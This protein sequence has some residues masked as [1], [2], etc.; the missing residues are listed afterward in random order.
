MPGSI[1]PVWVPE[2][3]ETKL[4]SM[5]AFPVDL[6]IPQESRESPRRKR[7]PLLL[8]F[9]AAMLLP[10]T[11]H[12]T[13][14]RNPAVFLLLID[15]IRLA[16]CASIFVSARHAGVKEGI[17]AT[18]FLGVVFL[19]A[20]MLDF[21][22][23]LSFGGAWETGDLGTGFSSSSVAR[24]I[25]AFGIFMYPLILRRRITER[26]W[27]PWALLLML[28]LTGFSV[29]GQTA[30]RETVVGAG[31]VGRWSRIGAPTALCFAA[32]YTFVQRHTMETRLSRAI[33]G[34]ALGTAA[35]Q[36]LL[37]L[38]P[39]S[40]P[41]NYLFAHATKTF[42]IVPLFLAVVHLNVAKP[43]N[44][45]LQRLRMSESGLRAAYGMQE[46]RIAE[47][48]A[49]LENVLERLK[50]N[51]RR[52][53][54]I[55]D[56][57]KDFVWL[58]NFDGLTVEYASPSF[59]RIW[60]NS[61]ENLYSDPEILVNGIHPEDR[62]R[63][64]LA[65][66][67]ERERG[68]SMEYRVLH[69][70]GSIRWIRDRAFPVNEDGYAGL[71]GVATDI[72]DEILLR[73]EIENHRQSL[74]K[75]VSSRTEELRAAN[76][77]LEADIEQRRKA[78]RALKQREKLF[79]SVV[80]QSHD[81]V[82]IVN[83]RG[84]VIEW[85]ERMATISGI[86]YQQACGKPILDIWDEL[87]LGA[88]SET[89][90]PE[91][92]A[93]QVRNLV[94][95]GIEPDW[96]GVGEV[97]ILTSNQERRLVGVSIF[98]VTGI[99][100]LIT[101]AIVRDV[102]KD[103]EN[104]ARTESA[105][106][107]PSENPH[108][109]L[110][111]S[112]EG[113]V[114][115]AN[116][117]SEI[118]LNRWGTGAG[119]KVPD[120]ICALVLEVWN[121]KSGRNCEVRICEKTFSLD[122]IPVA[123]S[124]YVNMYGR[125]IS[126][127]IA[128][129]NRVVESEDKHRQLLENLNEGLWSFDKDGKT[130]F[131]NRKM[132]AML[133]CS[134]EELRQK[135]VR[136]FIFPGDGTGM[137][138]D[139]IRRSEEKTG[140]LELELVRCDGSRLWALLEVSSLENEE[141]ESGGTLACVL[142][143]SSRKTAERMNAAL[144]EINAELLTGH[145]TRTILRK[146]IEKASVALL[147]ESAAILMREEGCWVVREQ[148]GML[149]LRTGTVLGDH[150]VVLAHRAVTA[151]TVI[152]IENADDDLQA[153]A[154][155]M[156]PENTGSVIIVPILMWKTTVGVMYFRNASISSEARNF[157]EGVGAAL[158]L[159]LESSRLFDEL[160]NELTARRRV[161]EELRDTQS[162][163]SELV[164]RQKHELVH[165]RETL[166]E[167]IDQRVEAQRALSQRQLA[168]E[169]VY[170]MATTFGTSLGTLFDQVTLSIA[171]ILDIEFVSIHNVQDGR[172]CALSQ[173]FHGRLTK[174]TD[175]AVPCSMCR[176]S[177]D[178]KLLVQHSQNLRNRFPEGACFQAHEFRSIVS[179]PMVSGSGESVGDICAMSFEDRKFSEYEIHLV[180]I[181]ARYI[182]HEISRT[183]LESKLRQSQEMELLGQLTS[184]VAHEVRNPLNGIV[185]IMEALF[186]DIGD[187]PE[188]DPY[189][190]HM[191]TQVTRLT[192]LM[193]EL[194]ALGRPIY[195]EQMES[196]KITSI[197]RAAVDSW[198]HAASDS[199]DLDIVCSDEL[200]ET[201]II[202]DHSKLEQVFVNLLQNAGQHS[203]RQ[204][205]IVVR[206]EHEGPEAVRVSVVDRGTGI[207]EK[208]L[209]RIF[210]PFYTT[211]KAG[212]GLGLSIV[213]HIVESHGGAIEAHN[214]SPEPGLTVSVR[215]PL[216]CIV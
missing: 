32:G 130:I 197:I 200:K 79:R 64:R 187:N 118:L 25:E 152:T 3:P 131:A 31:V 170:A 150:E 23:T 116:Q 115:Y 109:I 196:V 99:S 127:R 59:E 48:T 149:Y 185:A 90:D 98:R 15:T 180:E 119:K 213:R 183:R 208:S 46:K 14:I 78:E 84:E 168:L 17:G 63:V 100:K 161:E 193:E 40:G 175:A 61:V 120:N 104:A 38:F 102:T 172:I 216:G 103:R 133:G 67:Q 35:A 6:L 164:R 22:S 108:P 167:E 19:N 52:L 66:E 10:V 144:N 194:L 157:A 57:I 24:H 68:Y 75:L 93:T 96:P 122:L 124:G 4:S 11:H 80:R 94:E 12:F 60:G 76:R 121:S 83:G 87:T 212:T 163:L 166:A 209:T 88:S 101:G 65:F 125:D 195:K 26:Q 173:V 54:L 8:V 176:A 27:L 20:G 49:A 72:T 55:T 44:S 162:R 171:D 188:Y 74:E 145:Q 114:M 50:A 184:G 210:E 53:R 58:R 16:L 81:G 33:M 151:Q 95:Q 204:D 192:T 39:D 159:S 85:N 9:L 136:D 112:P 141:G 45:L 105:A 191:K 86:S 69:P 111:T 97:Q 165:T 140:Q 156:I 92:F 77:K 21:L 123:Q 203:P 29:L 160:K 205:A 2:N 215:L 202:A 71:A 5:N 201:T 18:T 138:P 199:R 62:N 206:I 106:K 142:D 28:A 110:R 135:N 178:K 117:A 43:Y 153:G 211:R 1:H 132:A 30:E 37:V 89:M 181:F 179:I 177:S 126:D 70:D 137:L 13:Q 128:Y 82:I 158:S 51:S 186:Q 107:F 73:N 91:S 134:L 139:L 190:M 174:G 56:T 41:N 182:A 214:N 154:D 198:R 47:R 113:T 34:V 129:E 146:V 169:A 36:A 155:T 207:P 189:L 7:L 42:V 147:A 148:E 143:I